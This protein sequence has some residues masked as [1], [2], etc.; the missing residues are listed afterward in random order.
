M[1]SEH[2]RSWVAE[3]VD[4]IWPVHH[5]TKSTF[6]IHPQS[7]LEYIELTETLGGAQCVYDAHTIYTY[8][9]GRLCLKASKL[10]HSDPSSIAIIQPGPTTS[11]LEIFRV[12]DGNGT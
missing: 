9:S 8:P 3:G 4:L 6:Q 5:Q 2:R 12:S 11:S 10:Q 1:W 7:T